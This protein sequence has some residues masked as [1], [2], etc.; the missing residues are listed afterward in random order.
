M[1]HFLILFLLVSSI[2]KANVS[3]EDST[4]Y[5]TLPDSVKA[6]QLIANVNV[7]SFVSGKEVFAGIATDRVQL[8]LHATRKKREVVFRFPS[9]AIVAAQ[10]LQTGSSKGEFSWNLEWSNN[11]TYKLLIAH[12]S[13]SAANFSLYS[14]Y[15]WL[16]K[17]AKWK[18]IGTCKINGEWKSIRNPAG[19]FSNEA[20]GIQASINDVWVQRN[21]GS[22]KTLDATT[23]PIPSIN[24]LSHID[25]LAQYEK[26]KKIITLA[27]ADGK[28]DAKDQVDAVFYKIINQGSGR[29]VQVDDTVTVF[30]KLTLF[31]DTAIIDGTKDKPA[32]FPLKRLIK[33]WQVGLPLIKTG[34]KIKLIVPSA[35]GY[36]VRT[37]AA[38]IPPNSILEFEL[39]VID[40]K[41]LI[42]N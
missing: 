33:G 8:L 21:N 25:S 3:S 24:L 12:A 32:V 6:I 2:C 13:D 4:I 39:E 41:S 18:L 35:Y 15:I 28:T 31:K 5:Y 38:K 11:E 22:W 19:K 29:Q 10:G 9:S 37:R 1:K 7:K 14:G 16:P 30:Y 26:E 34:G 20:T 42:K 23:G 36:S 27:I 17:E 40:T